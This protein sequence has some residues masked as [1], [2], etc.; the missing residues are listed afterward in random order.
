MRMH[1]SLGRRKVFDHLEG[2]LQTLVIVVLG[3]IRQLDDQSLVAMMLAHQLTV[4]RFLVKQLALL[5]ELY[6]GTST[7]D[8][9]V[10]TGPPSRDQSLAGVR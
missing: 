3:Q 4:N 6:V 8:S 10:C 5:L 1:I 2:G 9:H 7:R